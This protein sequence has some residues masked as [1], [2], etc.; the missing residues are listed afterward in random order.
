MNTIDLVKSLEKSAFLS[1]GTRIE[2]I[3]KSPVKLPYSKILEI[4]TSRL[5]KPFKC[6]VR[7]FWNQDMSV[8]IPE[9][10]SLCIYRY[11]FFEEDLTGM[12]LQYLK[13]GMT[14]FD[15]GAHFGYFTLLA[16][17]LVGSKGQV[18]SFEPTPSTFSILQSNTSETDNVFLN[19]CAVS[20]EKKQVLLNDCGLEYCAFN[21]IYKTRL[22]NKTL[23][24]LRIK[25][26]A[27]ECI[28]IDDYIKEKG[29]VPNF[30]KIDAER[31]EYEILVGME[32][33]IKSFHPI[34]SLE[35]GDEVSDIAGSKEAI[36][37]LM[38][39]DYLPYEFKD[40]NIF[41]HEVQKEDYKYN[42]ILFLPV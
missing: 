21:S 8:I 16:S 11:G 29:V 2:R 9:R 4:I 7:T 17:F 25:E 15:I 19:N 12:V 24:K 20:S 33:T 36:N 27:T 14:F 40:G 6:K 30:V 1:K 34:I 39:N 18:H 5:Q 32:K 26:F 23:S 42:N 22:P 41:K 13:P 38:K 10:V 35:L 31:A 28:S 3:K 37:F